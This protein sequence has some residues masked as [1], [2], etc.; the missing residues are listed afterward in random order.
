MC[1]WKPNSQSFGRENINR[2][3]K[4]F[5]SL[6]H[7]KYLREKE[8]KYRH[9]IFSNLKF[10]KRERTLTYRKLT[11][12]RRN[13]WIGTKQFV[14]PSKE[15]ATFSIGFSTTKTFA[16]AIARASLHKTHD[17][18]VSSAGSRGGGPKVSTSKGPPKFLKRRIM[19]HLHLTIN[20]NAS[21]RMLHFTGQFSNTSA[22]ECVT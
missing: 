21:S 4:L 1:G 8:E 22:L 16:N 7:S 2:E 11:N 12:K 15:R 5:L 13:N 19:F 17:C 6:P 10:L 14:A 20:A 18:Y 3:R 9:F